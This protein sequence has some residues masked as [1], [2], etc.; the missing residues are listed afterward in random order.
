M[1][2][3]HLFVLGFAVAVVSGAAVGATIGGEPATPI[4]GGVPLAASDGPSVTVYGDLNATLGDFTPDSNTVAVTTD[5]GNITLSSS[6]PTSAAVYP[7]VNATGRWTNVTDIT[8]GGTQLT[9]EPA[10]KPVVTTKG[11]TTDLSV[12]D[13]MATDDGT[14]DFYVN[15]TNGGTATVT[16]SGGWGLPGSRTISAVD[17]TTGNVLGVSSSA[18]SGEVTFDIGLS[19]HAVVLQ[20]GNKASAPELTN[21]SPTGDLQT[22]PSQLSIDINDSDFAGGDTVNYEILLDGT[23]QTTGSITSNQTITVPIP[24]SARIAGPHQWTVETSD[25]FG[26]S[27]TEVY[28]YSAPANLTIRNVSKPSQKITGANV[29]IT[30]YGDGVVSRSYTAT[31]G[32]VNMTGW[33]T[34]EVLIVRITDAPNYYDRTVALK[35]IYDQQDVYLLN[36]NKSSE[37]VRFT[38]D[39]QTGT[40]PEDASYITVNRALNVNNTTQYIRVAGGSASVNGATVR[41]AKGD[42]VQ[43]VVFNEDGDERQLGGYDVEVGETVNLQIGNLRLEPEGA[44]TYSVAAAYDNSS[45]AVRF[46]YQDP[47]DSTDQIDLLIYERGNRSNEALDQTFTGTYGNLSVTEPVSKNVSAWVVEWEIDRGD[48]T[49]TGQTI[50]GPGVDVNPGLSQFWQSFIGVSLLVVVTGLFGGLRA[51]LGAV[52]VPLLA[53]VLWFLGWLPAAVGAGAILLAL[54]VGIIY[55]TSS[56]QGVPGA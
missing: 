9:I 45:T 8:S 19:S 24:Q 16:L 49:I 11:D 32:T 27:E 42:R 55:L 38:L 20:S 18:A 50:V 22:R 41:L 48:E 21:P 44:N 13:S 46:E 2:Y 14:V 25:S 56:P 1:N 17:A 52:V 6:G 51:Q 12:R 37:Q 10:N 39:D 35:S 7:G 23:T 26:K 30:A 47:T 5:E 40:F 34:D 15:G 31:D 33:P 53:G 28:E 36:D 4:D 43:L 54:G 3:K 29:S